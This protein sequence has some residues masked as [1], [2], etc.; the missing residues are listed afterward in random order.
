[1]PNEIELWA[2]FRQKPGKVASLVRLCFRDRWKLH[3][4]LQAIV[5]CYFFESLRV[6]STKV[7]VAKVMGVH[8]NTITSKFKEYGIDDTKLEEIRNVRD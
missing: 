1:M 7:E 2:Q 5:R 8:H 4:L 3:N 6:R